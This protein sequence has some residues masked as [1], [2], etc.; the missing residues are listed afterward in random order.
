[1]TSSQHRFRSKSGIILIRK[2]S[3]NGGKE[4]LL[5][6]IPLTPTFRPITS[7]LSTRDLSWVPFPN[8]D[9][10]VSLVC[11]LSLLRMDPS[12]L[13]TIE[14]T[15]VPGYK[16]SCSCMFSFRIRLITFYNHSSLFYTNAIYVLSLLVHGN[17]ST[18]G[19]LQGI[20]YTPVVYNY[21]E[22]PPNIYKLSLAAPA[23]WGLYVTPGWQRALGERWLNTRGIM[24]RGA[25]KV[26]W[27]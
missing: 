26:Q 1:M 20:F 25:I 5:R 22:V 21:L 12:W 27:T 24:T 11:S 15:R 7:L 6:G 2:I 14:H 8:C 19:A 9:R 23:E 10:E 16:D 3:Q 17:N 18:F 13:A 4:L